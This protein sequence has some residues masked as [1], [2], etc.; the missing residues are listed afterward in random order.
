MTKVDA[1]N[2]MVNPKTFAK[3]INPVA[4]ILS[5]IPNHLSAI[6]TGAGRR[7]N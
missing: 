7:N 5:E 4:V 1:K 2:P 3:S 6:Y